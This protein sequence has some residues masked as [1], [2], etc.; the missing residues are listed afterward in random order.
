MLGFRDHSAFGDSGEFDQPVPY[1]EQR[2]SGLHFDQAGQLP[3]R[4]LG[5]GEL[6]DIQGSKTPFRPLEEVV[7]HEPAGDRKFL[8][9]GS[10][11]CS[12]YEVYFFD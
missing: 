9:F 3:K 4:D 8:Q 5:T 7:G 6:G 10:N 1:G 2:V 11:I 12:V